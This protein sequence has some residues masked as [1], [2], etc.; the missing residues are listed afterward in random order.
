M[1]HW[2]HV[3]GGADLKDND[4]LLGGVRYFVDQYTCFIKRSSNTQFV[5]GV[6]TFGAGQ[7]WVELEVVKSKLTN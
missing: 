3:P 1:T 2:V 4:R 6:E 7:Q 5:H